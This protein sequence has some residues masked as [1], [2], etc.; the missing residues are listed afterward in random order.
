MTDLRRL[1]RYHNLSNDNNDNDNSSTPALHFNELK[2]FYKKNNQKELPGWNKTPFGHK[3]TSL[4]RVLANAKKRIEKSTRFINK[5]KAID[6]ACAD[7]LKVI[8]GNATI[9]KEYV[10]VEKSFVIKAWALPLR[11]LE[12]P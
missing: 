3:I 9:R 8:P 4:L 6:L 10:N 5:V 12:R 1:G 2:W 11:L 7:R